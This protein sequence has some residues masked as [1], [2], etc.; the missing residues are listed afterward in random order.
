MLRP[1]KIRAFSSFA[2]SAAL[3]FPAVASAQDYFA[4]P[5]LLSNDVLWTN[6]LAIS[7][8]DGDN[9]L[10]VIVAN[11]SGFFSTPGPQAF[12]VFTNNGTGTF[13]DGTAAVLGAGFS[14]PVRQFAIGD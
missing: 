4:A 7:D 13:T 9:D 10:D 1:A 12:Q 5:T 3:F 6:Y 14:K 8:L 11:C 2:F